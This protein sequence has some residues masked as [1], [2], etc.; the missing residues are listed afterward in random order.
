MFGVVG[1]KFNRLASMM[2]EKLRR[3]WAACEAMALGRGGIAAVSRE[4]GISRTT[5]RKGIAEIREEMPELAGQ[6]ESQ[7]IRKEGG[8]RR[9]LAESDRRLLKDLLKLVEA[10]TRGDPQCPLL[11]TCKS[12]R[13]LSAELTEQGHQVSPQTVSRLLHEMGYSLQANRKTVEGASHPDRNAQFAHINKKVK[14]FHRRGEPVISVDTKKRE[15]VGNFRNSGSEW[16]SKGKP[17]E[18]RIHDFRDKELGVAIPY[19]VY[20]PEQDEGWVNVGIDHDTSQFAVESIR[21]WWNR[22]GR[23][24]HPHATAV[25]ITADSGGS[26]GPRNRLWKVE[27]QRFA[28][29]TGLKVSVCHFPPGTSKWNA[30]EHSLFCHITENWRGRPLISRTVI[31][32]LIG[33]TT[34]TKGLRVKAEL[35]PG[36]YPNG[37]K[38]DDATFAA[39]NMHNDRFHGDWNYSL[40]PR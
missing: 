22:M 18:V 28:D 33:H 8:G 16:R 40:T 35:D 39:I 19:G 11:W 20:D 2:N 12:T 24:S 4:T 38:V 14:N 25:L 27:L 10:S 7:R 23:Y 37:I 3:R 5:I 32:N 26:N 6:V 13:R 30:I 31:V 1:M 36:S 29:E 17:N 21:R 15:L 34:T 9:R